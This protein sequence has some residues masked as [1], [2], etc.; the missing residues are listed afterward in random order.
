MRCSGRGG[1]G[2]RR[3]FRAMA[4]A[5]RWKICAFGRGRMER[6]EGKSRRDGAA[7]DAAATSWSV[8]GDTKERTAQSRPA[9][10]GPPP[11]RLSVACLACETGPGGVRRDLVRHRGRAGPQVTFLSDHR[12]TGPSHTLPSSHSGHNWSPYDALL[13]PPSARYDGTTAVGAAL[14]RISVQRYEGLSA[15]SVVASRPGRRPPW[16]AALAGRLSGS[17]VCPRHRLAERT[18]QAGQAG[19]RPICLLGVL[20]TKPRR[21]GAV[22]VI[23]SPWP[24]RGRQS[25]HCLWAPPIPKSSS[26]EFSSPRT[27][28]KQKF[29]RGKYLV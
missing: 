19:R 8:K 18:R 1:W 9:M 26:R 24:G 12:S 6:L 20:D 25:G 7:R 23:P 21:S 4:V 10:S 5:R 3:R 28:Y 27:A 16:G 13:P 11:P 14:S 2:A 17:R 22:V 29:R 15:E